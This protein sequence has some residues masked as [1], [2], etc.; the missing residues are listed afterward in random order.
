MK[1]DRDVYE[2][3]AEESHAAWMRR[4][5]VFVAEK[6][7]GIESHGGIVHPIELDHDQVA[8]R[9]PAYSTQIADAWLV[10]EKLKER[11]DIEISCNVQGWTMYVYNDTYS[12]I[13]AATAPLAI[14]LAALKATE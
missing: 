12:G 3:W 7:M 6:V 14:C 1:T 4:I 13:Y 8:T 5:D 11:F 9:V 2:K 10:V